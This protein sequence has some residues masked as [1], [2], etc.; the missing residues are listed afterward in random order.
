MQASPSLSP[1]LS[2]T[3]L[4]SEYRVRDCVLQPFPS[5]D[6]KVV[7]I[8]RHTPSDTVHASALR[9]KR[10]EAVRAS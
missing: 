8:W 6:P 3:P 10:P 1:P 5:P 7:G 2:L 4:N 9:K